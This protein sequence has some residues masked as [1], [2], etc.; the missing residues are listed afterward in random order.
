MRRK[1]GNIRKKSQK[2]RKAANKWTTKQRTGEEEKRE[3]RRVD[4]REKT[5]KKN[6][7]DEEKDD[8]KVVALVFCGLK[9][10]SSFWELIQAVELFRS[11][12]Q[13]AALDL[14]MDFCHTAETLMGRTHSTYVNAL[15]TWRKSATFGRH[16][17]NCAVLRPPWLRL[18]NKWVA[19][20]KLGNCCRKQKSCIRMGSTEF[21]VLGTSG[22][23]HGRCEHADF[24]VSQNNWLVKLLSCQ[25]LVP[26]FGFR[27]SDDTSVAAC[28]HNREEAFWTNHHANPYLKMQAVSACS[29]WCGTVAPHNFAWKALVIFLKTCTYFPTC[30][31][32]FC[33]GGVSGSKWVSCSILRVCVRSTKKAWKAC[34]G[35]RDD[36]SLQQ[37][38]SQQTVKTWMSLKKKHQKHHAW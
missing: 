31:V 37:V 2:G 15:V 12:Q 6:R 22:F 27:C 26:W 32:F 17:R 25:L 35:W 29:V 20:R 21:S 14:A 36:A 1:R 9:S 19:Q 23:G 33:L 7:F 5:A 11:G 24:F 3:K 28:L 34:P 8:E 16:F 13:Q 38:V 10:L 4:R 18:Q 30:L